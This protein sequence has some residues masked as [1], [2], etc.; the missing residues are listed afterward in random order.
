M[1]GCKSETSSRII[2]EIP[3]GKDRSGKRERITRH[4]LYSLGK[5]LY[6][7]LS[8]RTLAREEYAEGEDDL[9]TRDAGPGMHFVY[10]LF[11]K[12][13]TE[14]PQDRY[15]SAADLLYALDTVIE[16]VQ[17]K[18]HVLKPSL[19]QHCM[20]C[21]VGE[22]QPSRGSG[23][24]DFLFFCNNC[25]NQQSFVSSSSKPWWEK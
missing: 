2:S 17:L 21:V 5:V 16:R 11:D 23:S 25:G 19:R 6:F 24:N 14:R 8:G 15:Q 3:P 1:L 13:I 4:A 12:T 9:R 7:I 20:F 10:E 18:A 22:Y